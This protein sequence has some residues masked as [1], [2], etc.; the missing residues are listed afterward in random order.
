MADVKKPS[1][2]L[3]F[4]ERIKQLGHDIT[5]RDDGPKIETSRMPEEEI[6]PSRDSIQ[7]GEGSR[8]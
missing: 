6:K 4:E 3:A 7:L 8:K 2:D 5:H 1:Y